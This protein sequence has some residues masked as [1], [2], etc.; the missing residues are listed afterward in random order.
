MHSNE[1]SNSTDLE[2]TQVRDDNLNEQKI[3][4]GYILENAK[5]FMGFMKF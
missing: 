4:E 5:S 2:R 1:T 3:V